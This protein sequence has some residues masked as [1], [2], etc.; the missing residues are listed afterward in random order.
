M[1]EG[2]VVESPLLDMPGADA[3]AFEELFPPTLRAGQAVSGR[4]REHRFPALFHGRRR[5]CRHA[6]RAWRVM[7]EWLPPRQADVR[8][9][10]RFFIGQ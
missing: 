8:W 9:R 1:A 10:K 5:G 3:P 4:R 7:Q 6:A 2:R